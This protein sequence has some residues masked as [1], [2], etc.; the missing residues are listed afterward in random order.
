MSIASVLQSPADI[1]ADVAGPHL[2][3]WYTFAAVEQKSGADENCC[4]MTYGNQ[5]RVKEVSG[6]SCNIPPYGEFCEYIIKRPWGKQD[7]RA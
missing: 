1:A 6:K 7:N 3:S 5:K 4:M 2:E